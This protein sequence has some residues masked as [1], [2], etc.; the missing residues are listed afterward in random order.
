MYAEGEYDLAGSSWEL[1]AFQLL[2]GKR[3]RRG[4]V[5]LALPSSGL[6]TNGYS[7]ARRLLFDRAGYGPRTLLPESARA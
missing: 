2:T 1:R 7:L 6:H 5:L 4:D 3:I